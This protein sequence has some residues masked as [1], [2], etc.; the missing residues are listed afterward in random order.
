[1]GLLTLESGNINVFTDRSL[2]LAQS[3]VFTEQGGDVTIWSS[4]G[5]INAGQGAK[6]SS[7]V[8]PPTFLCD[9]DAWCRV[10][11]RGQVSGAGIATLQSVEGAPQGNAYLIAPRGTVDAGD[12]GIRVSGN[13]VIAAARVANADNIQVK[14]D[15]VGIPV[16]ASVN[17]GALNAAGA[18]ATAATQAAEDVARKQQSD[19]R[20][21]LPSEISVH[22]LSD[23]DNTSSVSPGSYDSSSPVQVLGRGDGTGQLTDAE[24]KA[25]HRM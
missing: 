11:A 20:D 23:G 22:V 21:K 18:A 19:A 24:R 9:V 10:D 12:A 7:E 2:L 1:M 25:L 3:R 15:S 6:T 4:N 8:P 5:D 14:G 13:L 16:T 17:V